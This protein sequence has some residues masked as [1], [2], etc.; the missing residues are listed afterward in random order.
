MTTRFLRPELLALVVPVVLFASAACDPGPDQV[1]YRQAHQAAMAGQGE[2][3]EALYR[4]LFAEHPTSRLKPDAHL[5][6]G[7]LLY[8][9]GDFEAALVAYE[10]VTRGPGRKSWGYAL[11]KQGLCQ[12]NRREPAKA[13]RIFQ[14][15]ITLG[16]EGAIAPDERRSLVREARRDLVKAYAARLPAVGASDYFRRWGGP[17]TEALL[18]ALGALYLERKK[19]DAA[20]SMHRELIA[21]Y[22]DSQ[23]LCV[24]QEA[25]LRAA[26]MGNDR[27]IQVAEAQR[28]GAV[29]ARLEE[30]PDVP[31]EA[32]E[33]CRTGLRDTLKELA[34]LVHRKAQK[35]KDPAQYDLADPLYRQYLTRFRDE[36]DAYAM[37]FYHGEL[38]WMLGRWEDAAE[39]YR[40]VV[41]MNPQGEYL[42][43]AALGTV[44]A[45][46]NA[47][48]VGDDVGLPDEARQSGHQ[49]GVIPPATRRMLE[50][51]DLYVR[52]VP[53]APELVKVKYRRARIFY[54][55]NH[56][57]E[58]ARAFGAIVDVHP[59][60]ELA[61]YAA[62]L[63][64]DAWNVLGR[65]DVV[66]ARLESVQGGPLT[67]RNP[68]LRD[69]FQLLLAD[70]R[71]GK[72]ADKK[73][74]PRPTP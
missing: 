31:A 20:T 71:G 15:V 7:E 73:A 58:A 34:L 13:Q 22:P 11:Y 21:T 37:T 24:W 41:E 42:K 65:Q 36:K 9:R 44:L 53:E 66:C 54:E 47:L 26:L 10:A 1:L 70:C 38:L 6:L 14:E 52:H 63:E 57:E 2:E 4:K 5:A 8:R 74:H 30:T 28:L 60:H 33:A 43:E 72:T 32:L 23:K 48:E 64:I 62:N 39:E 61:A 27:K 29:L 67:A 12:L 69:T 46:Q 59:E 40:R 25:I 51:Y 3:A 50:A 55:H 45:W 35:T 56:L 19:T 49:P 18:T 16:E 68:E 17:E